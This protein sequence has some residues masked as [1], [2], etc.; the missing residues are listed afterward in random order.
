MPITPLHYS[1]TYVINKV[2]G[3]LIL[4]ALIVGSLIPDVEPFVN[5]VTGGILVPPR[6]LMHSILGAVTL[7]T[8]LAALITIFLYPL[9]VTLIFKV[10]KK[11]VAEKCRF[12]QMFVLSALIGSFFHV[13]IDSTSHEYNPLLY[14][15]MTES[16]DVL[17]FMNDWLLAAI[18]V[19]TVLLGMLLAVFVYEI[20]KGTEGFW[21]R[22]LVG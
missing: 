16:F 5:L 12:S 2:K 1:L 6:G 19:Q 7:D 3:G 11:D 13:L 17:V 4:P 21:K 8:F 18:I 10:E 20:R 14:P 15:F 9:L 22:L